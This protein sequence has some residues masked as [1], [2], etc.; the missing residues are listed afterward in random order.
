MKVSKVINVNK[1]THTIPLTLLI[2]KQNSYL[3]GLEVREA[4]LEACK[5]EGQRFKSPYWQS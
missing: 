1:N 4:S 5:L 3:H 2:K